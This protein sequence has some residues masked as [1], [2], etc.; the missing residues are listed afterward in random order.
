MP[1]NLGNQC[2]LLDAGYDP[3]LP[4]A[5]GTGLDV[6]GKDPLEALSSAHGSGWLV[7][8]DVATGPARYDACPDGDDLRT[9]LSVA[10]TCKRSDFCYFYPCR[11]VPSHVHPGKIVTC[12]GGHANIDRN[13]GC[14]VGRMSQLPIKG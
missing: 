8:I 2:R 6:D 3:Q 4:T 7:S 13:N 11:R 5:M 1:Q 9:M 10:G 12:P 14:A